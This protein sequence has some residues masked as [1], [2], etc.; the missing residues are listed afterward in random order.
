[1]VDSAQHMSLRVTS[2]WVL[3]T[4]TATIVNSFSNFLGR[5]LPQTLQGSSAGADVERVKR[6]I[7]EVI[8][9][10]CS[11]AILASAKQVSLDASWLRSD[12]ANFT[13]SHYQHTIGIFD[14]TPACF[15]LAPQLVFS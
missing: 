4:Q 15:A 5:P 8:G 13:A 12:Q 2:A 9:I 7:E 14:T 1:M 11:N 3:L 10:D 6:E